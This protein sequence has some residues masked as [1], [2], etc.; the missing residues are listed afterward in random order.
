MATDV[1]LIANGV[2]YYLSNSTGSPVSGGAATAAATTPFA[3]LNDGWAM[4]AAQ[5]AAAYSGGPPFRLGSTL[6]YQSYPNTVQS[7]PL[8]VSG[9]SHDNAASLLRNLRQQINQAI[10]GLACV[11]YYQPSTATNPLY[12]EVQ[13]GAIQERPDPTNPVRG[14]AY[15]EADMVLTL[16]PLG[17]LLSSGET[18]LNAQ[19]FTVAGSTVTLPTN[20]F[21]YSAGAGDF[22]YEGSP[23]NIKVTPTTASSDIGELWCASVWAAAS[24]TSNNALNAPGGTAITALWTPSTALSHNGS[25]LRVIARVSN[26]TGGAVSKYYIILRGSSGTGAPAI[27]SSLS[28]GISPTIESTGLV[29]FGP[30]PVDVFRSISPL[31]GSITVEFYATKTAGTCTLIS[32][33]FLIYTDF[34]KITGILAT[35]ASSRYL[36]LNGFRA[37]SNQICLPTAQSATNLTS[38]DALYSPCVLRGQL[39]RYF[40]GSSL[41]MNWLD[42]T[43]NNTATGTRAASVT[44]TH[45]PL[46]FTMR[47]AG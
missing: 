4:Q 29:D 9:S 31:T 23:L 38:A 16:Y 44:A 2:T 5:P 7:I 39:P 8:T 34:C 35:Q 21:A 36:W 30:I 45:G 1:R 24:A 19:T 10:S 26:T 27:W 46:W 18:L 42:S 17:G 22:I 11:L 33:E 25:K 37:K 47:G 28:T 40:S 6:A 43:G 15:L 20:S 32:V 3:L 12:Y 41:W 14:F 13:S